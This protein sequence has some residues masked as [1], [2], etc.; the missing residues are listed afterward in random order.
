MIKFILGGAG[1]GKST[2]LI[3][4]IQRKVQEEEEILTLVP[5]QF[6]YEFDKKLYHILGAKQFNRLETHSFK[7]L[8]RAIFQRYGSTPDGKENADDLTRT[9]LLYQA[10]QQVA[11]RENKLTIL[12]KQCQQTAFVDEVSMLLSQFR[13]SGITPAFLYESCGTLN[14]RLLEKTMDLFHIYQAYDCLL[15]AHHLKDVETEL[16]EAAAIANGQD[17]FLGKT[18]FL[19]EFESFTEDEYELLQ[20]LFALC[21]DV[22]IALRTDE[23]EQKPF[24]L[25]ETV[26]ET[27]YRLS[28]M[29][30]ELHIPVDTLYCNTA[31][32]FHT[33]DL[34]WLSH[35]VFRSTAAFCDNS[36]QIHILEASTP[37][38]EAEFVCA[39]IRRLLAQDQALRCRD[40]AVLT[41]QFSD[42]QSVLETAMLRYE[43]PYHMDEKQSIL[44]APLMIYLHTLSSLMQKK[45]PST[46]LLMRLGKTG[47]TVCTLSEISILENYCY[48]WQIDGA[49]WEKPF[50][51]GDAE[52]AEKLRQKLWTPFEELKKCCK[53][54]KEGAAYCRIFYDF[55]IAQGVEERLTE[56]LSHIAEESQRMQAQED[57]NHVWNSWIDILD[58]M[59]QLY[60]DVPMELSEFCTIFLA[61]TKHIQRVVPPRTLDAVMISQGSTARLNAPKIVFLL[62][63]CEGTFPAAASGNGIFSEKDFLKMEKVKIPVAKPKE[64]QMADARLAAY[65][66]LSAASH[67]LYLTYPLVDI[68]QQKCYPASVLL[69]IQRMFPR[70]EA[71]KQQCITFCGS[72]YATTLHAAYY[73]YVQDYSEYGSDTASIE[74]VLMRDPFYQKRLLHLENLVQN[75]QGNP[76][77]PLFQVK[78][79]DLMQRYLG[80]SIQLSASALNRYQ[81]CPFQYFCQ[82]ILHLFRR[83]KVQMAGAGSGSMIHYCLEQILKQYDRDA[84]LALTPEKLLS[85]TVQYAEKF[86]ENEMGGDFSKSFREQAVYSH[87][88]SG[89]QELMRHLQEEFSHSK[90]YPRYLELPISPS[91]K[92]FPPVDLRTRDGQK[93]CLTGSVDRV[94][95]CQ[96][97]DQLW[98]RV[99]DYKSDAKQF[100]IGNL[101]YGLDLQMLIYLFTITSPQTL[102][103]AAKPAGVLYMPSGSAQSGLVRGENGSVQEYFEKTYRM[104]GV[105]LKDANLISLM[106]PDGNGIYIPAQLDANHQLIEKSGTFVTW[107]QMKHLREY[108]FQQ[109]IHMAEQIYHGEIDANPLRLKEKSGCTYC[110]YATICGNASQTHGRCLEGRMSDREKQMLA[111]LEKG[112]DA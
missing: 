61:L 48:A 1:C 111:L 84:F 79:P 27:R 55:C 45:H 56:Q 85:S 28:R 44:H 13:R 51:G 66:L 81:L 36:E 50:T 47:M 7:S 11:T 49:T 39:T 88:V 34:A 107:E 108:V 26:N 29:A 14:G 112:E 63:V 8:A 58:H 41:N 24:S 30:S 33:P 12:K 32:R 20:V 16:T 18:L 103:S 71:L 53:G 62:G 87:V 6:S 75:G 52:V 37:N 31:Y 91:S 82:D 96:E 109:M 5:E 77:D 100:S 106:E 65:K 54:A 3:R 35:H 15:E 92:D 46:E 105:L 23:K 10:I 57:W 110:S 64:A 99:V 90:F 19:D 4:K 98:V 60:A 67:T 102:L 72:Y 93:I 76:E 101:L 25:F 83:Q 97:A 78:N 69:Q 94:D 68:T 86:W 22:V 42:Y 17:A 40:I 73:R 95:V 70:A 38:E 59:E 21:K 2:A 80:N 43:I 89:M 9:A 104:N 74:A